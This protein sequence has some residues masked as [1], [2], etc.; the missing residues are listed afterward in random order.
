LKGHDHDRTVLSLKFIYDGWDG[1]QTSLDNAIAPLSA[2]QL[3]WRPK[4]QLRSVGEIAIH[5]SFGRVGWFYNM[6]APGSAELISQTA[7]WEAQAALALDPVEQA[8][9]LRASWQ[10][11]AD[12]LD[13]WT[14]AD[15]EKSY[16]LGYQ[17]KTFNV[18]RQWTIWRVLSHDIHHGGQ[19]AILLGMQGVQ[20]PDL[21]D[22]GGHITM[23]PL[24]E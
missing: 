8:R 22:Q 20:I 18:S 3:A 13:Q 7:A 17:G 11:I 21:G 12:T 2:E 14:A 23:P 9:W 1:Y 16:Q 19:I 6:K 4:P 15:L 10:M 24:A 5:I